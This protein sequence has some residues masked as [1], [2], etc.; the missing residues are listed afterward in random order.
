M[1]FEIS[2][3]Q[4]DFA[5]YQ[6]LIHFY[7]NAKQYCKIDIGFNFWFA[8][9]MSAALGALLHKLQ[10]NGTNYKMN[11]CSNGIETI[12][13]KNGF[14]CKHFSADTQDDSHHTT[15]PYQVLRPSQSIF[16]N[17][18]VVHQ[19]FEREELPKMSKGV[20]DKMSELIHELFV[21]AQIH[22]NSEKVYTCGQFFPTKNK[23]EFTLVDTGIGFREKVNQKFNKGLL[24]TQAILWAVQD[25]NTTKDVT[26]GLGLAMLKE[27]TE[28]NNGKIQIVSY[29]G[30]YEFKKGN[31]NTRQFDGEFPGTIINIQFR[32]ND[33]TQYSL[34]E[35]LDITDIF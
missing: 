20:K 16:F 24:A 27:F 15:I 6:R 17:D 14:L 28:H 29:N 18:Y 8:A 21:N 31:E 1:N 33:N 13:R 19:L 11:Y 25:K 30:Y 22:S 35:E 7:N 32:T 23:I 5:S 3:I 26:G 4:N 34:K 12:L 10:E 2:N 9:N